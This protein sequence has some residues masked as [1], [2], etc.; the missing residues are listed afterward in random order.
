M[1]YT[2]HVLQIIL[3]HYLYVIGQDRPLGSGKN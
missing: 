3:Y 1:V 2:V